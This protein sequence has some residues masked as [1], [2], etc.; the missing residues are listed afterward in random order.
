MPNSTS[1]HGRIGSGTVPVV[2][3]CAIAAMH[4]NATASTKQRAPMRIATAPLARTTQLRRM[5]NVEDDSAPA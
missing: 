3:T 2:A 4:V 5:K 1:V